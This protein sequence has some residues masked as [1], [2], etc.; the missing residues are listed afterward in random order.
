MSLSPEP[1]AETFGL[2]F[3]LMTGLFGERQVLTYRSQ[4]G[5]NR[6]CPG[7]VTSC[8]WL[9]NWKIL[10]SYH[11]KSNLVLKKKSCRLM[12]IWSIHYKNVIKLNHLRNLHFQL[13]EKLPRIINEKTNRY[14]EALNFFTA[15]L[16]FK[17]FHFQIIVP[18]M[19]PFIIS[20]QIFP[21]WELCSCR[22]IF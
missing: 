2:P 17:T 4:S 5:S 15:M 10:E 19:Y 22:W 9:W 21:A 20:I 8:T 13:S 1:K 18:S 3:R 16:S 11:Q 6:H 12:S 14:F 7:G